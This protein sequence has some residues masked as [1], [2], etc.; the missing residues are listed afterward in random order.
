MLG[1]K[2]ALNY[3][4]PDIDRIRNGEWINSLQ[5]RKTKNFADAMYGIPDAVVVDVWM[6]RAFRVYARERRSPSTSIYDQIE[7]YV[8]FVA[9]HI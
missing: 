1:I 4:R 3:I 9:G 2:K 6:M 5:G 7:N 8:K